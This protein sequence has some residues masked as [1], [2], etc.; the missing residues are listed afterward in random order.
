MISVRRWLLARLIFLR[1][2]FTASRSPRFFSAIVVS[3]M[4]AFMGV[5][6]S[7]D[8]VERKSVFAL[9]ADSASL[10]M[11]R[12]FLLKESMYRTSI[13]SSSSNPAVTTPIS[14]QSTVSVFRS[15]TRAVLSS[16]HPLVEE[17]GVW[18][19]MHSRPFEFSMINEPVPDR[20]SANSFCCLSIPGWL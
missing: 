9:L 17:M 20:I 13:T 12:S 18:A 16:T 10:A 19:T 1:F 5:R 14:S 15:L 6:I 3:P 7:W 4:I 2:S 8:M 11:T